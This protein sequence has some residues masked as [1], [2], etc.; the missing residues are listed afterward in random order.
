MVLFLAVVYSYML[1]SI[2]AYH[3]NEFS[4]SNTN[5]GYAINYDI[6]KYITTMTYY[7][8]AH[9]QDRGMEIEIWQSKKILFYIDH[10]V[11]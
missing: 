10:R 2:I 5:S 9:T 8:L 7:K 3:Q 6:F 11:I 1:Q 4:L